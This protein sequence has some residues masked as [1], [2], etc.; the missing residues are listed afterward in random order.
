MNI[1]KVKLEDRLSKKTL[2]DFKKIFRVVENCIIAG[3]AA[4]QLYYDLELKEKDRFGSTD[5]DFFRYTKEL[6][7]VDLFTK[8]WIRKRTDWAETY[9]YRLSKFSKRQVTIQFIKKPYKTLED[10]FNSFDFTVCCFATDGEFLYYTEEA[11]KDTEKRQLKY[12]ENYDPKIHDCPNQRLVKYILKGFMPDKDIFLELSQRVIL[13]C[14]MNTLNEN[15]DGTRLSEKEVEAAQK[16][17]IDYYLEFGY[18]YHIEPI[19]DL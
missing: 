11:I 7:K 9:V 8:L 14:L 17:Y 4:R 13:D 12:I 1:L 19:N 18:R 15:W 10:I 3:G 5:I 2:Y 16:E 6:I